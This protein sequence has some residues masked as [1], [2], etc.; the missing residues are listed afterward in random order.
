MLLELEKVSQVKEEDFTQEF[1]N[2]VNVFKE[3]EAYDYVKDLR[4]AYDRHLSVSTA[5]K[6]F[7]TIPE[8]VFWDIKRPKNNEYKMVQNNY[9]PFRKHHTE[10][11]F[12]ARDYEE[13][14]ERRTHKNNL[15]D[16]VSLYRRY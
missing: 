13:Y 9:N 15:A 1:A 12:D 3:G 7:R 4:T 6:I 16:G 10:S 2:Q 14:M 11:F 8:W 5:Q